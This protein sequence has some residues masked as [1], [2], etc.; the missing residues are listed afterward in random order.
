MINVLCGIL[1]GVISSSIA[2]PT[3]VLKVIMHSVEFV[4][5]F[6]CLL[7]EEIQNLMNTRFAVVAPL[8]I[9]SYIFKKI[10]K[11][12]NSLNLLQIHTYYLEVCT[13]KLMV[14][15]V[16]QCILF[17]RSGLGRESYKMTLIFML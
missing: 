17:L 14:G 12:V 5:S 11:A 2:N 1:S 15:E 3:D 10:S 6:F 4:L 8:V 13:E 16:A 9:V 7:I